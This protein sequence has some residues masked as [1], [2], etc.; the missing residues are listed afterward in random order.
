MVAPVGRGSQQTTIVTKTAGGVTET[1]TI[2]VRFVPMI[3]PP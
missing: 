2:R 1:K 3:D